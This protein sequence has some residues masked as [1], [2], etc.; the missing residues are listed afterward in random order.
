MLLA[1]TGVPQKVNTEK[2]DEY[3]TEIYKKKCLKTLPAKV[4]PEKSTEEDLIADP[5]P[6]NAQIK[7]GDRLR[8]GS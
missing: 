7:S 8:K 5:A 6:Q 3:I 1:R 2:E 4:F